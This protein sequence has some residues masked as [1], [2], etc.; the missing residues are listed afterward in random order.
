M[1]DRC[2]LF[3]DIDG[4]LIDLAPHPDDVVVPAGLIAL[5][6]ALR[7]C[8]DGALALIS[9]R[10]LS[11]IDGLFGAGR[12]D[13]AGSHGYEWRTGAEG[14]RA[15]APPAPLFAAVADLVAKEA[16]LLPGL[17]VERKLYSIALH[18]RAAP[19]REPAAW[20][21]AR[22]ALARL[23]AGYHLQAGQ[24][25]VEIVPAAAEKGMAIERFMRAPPYRG[26]NPV[27]AGDDLT[28]ESGFQSVNHLGGWSVH[29]G[30]NE[31]SASYHLASPQALR[32]W[33]ETGFKCGKD[34]NG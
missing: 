11:Q 8:L 20:A 32:R 6:V 7:A 25:V 14:D 26:R 33:L 27:F 23:G 3:L 28:D 15:I 4:T 30:G 29:I 21:L 18:H 1:S 17:L 5:L 13:A 22:T 10:S 16:A 2:A 12:F 31:T 24:G 34:V 9:G 19:S